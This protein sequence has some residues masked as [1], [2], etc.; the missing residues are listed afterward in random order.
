MA[1]TVHAC[2]CTKGRH[3]RSGCRDFRPKDRIGPTRLR[4]LALVVAARDRGRTPTVKGM[5]RQ[6]GLRV[7]NGV[8][9]HLRALRRLGL[10]EWDAGKGGTL[11]PT[12]RFVPADALGK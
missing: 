8:A 9:V 3:H 2:G 6:L 1:A 4:V 11:R 10:V 12:C 5:A 7:H